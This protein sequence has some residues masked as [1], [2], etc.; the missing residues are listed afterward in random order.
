VIRTAALVVVAL[1]AVPAVSAA[2]PARLAPQVVHSGAHLNGAAIGVSPFDEALAV[3]GIDNGAIDPTLI[4]RV[5]GADGRFAATQELSRTTNAEVPYD[6]QFNS[7]GGTFLA[8]GIAT[9]GATGQ[10]AFRPRGGLFS[11]PVSWGEGLCSRNTSVRFLASGFPQVACSATN[12]TAPNDNALITTDS[13]N[14]SGTSFNLF[15]TLQA[16]VA[17]SELRPLLDVGPDGT[18]AIAWKVTEGS[19]F[20]LTEKIKVAVAPPGAG[21]APAQSVASVLSSIGGWVNLSDLAVLTDGR[22]AIGLTR[23]DGSSKTS[24]V[25]IRSTSGALDDAL[26]GPAMEG[27]VKVERDG[28][29]ALVSWTENTGFATPVTLKVASLAAG[30]TLT[31]VQTLERNVNGLDV[32]DLK[33]GSG[34]AGGNAGLLVQRP[35]TGGKAIGAWVR[36]ARGRSF[37]GP[38]TIATTNATFGTDFAVDRFGSIAA[39]W[40]EEGVPNGKVFFGGLDVAGPVLS[41]LSIPGRLRAGRSG[42]FSVRSVDPAGM[43]SVR[44]SFGDRGAATGNRVRHSYRRTGRYRVTVVA[45]DKVGKQSRA[46]RVVTVVR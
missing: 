18:R 27:S 17:G 7:A 15:S 26:I 9:S 16:G 12:G 14:Q 10:H 33:V 4:A 24:K 29:G 2:A 30:P 32:L 19:S 41:S 25:T 38:F 11:V 28:S 40:V 36:S 20:V 39:V 42:S 5:R 46:S 13:N 6:V 44:W 3:V 1:F 37:E 43:R 31:G 8:W 35:V 22:V 34:G 23:F 21:F 45:T